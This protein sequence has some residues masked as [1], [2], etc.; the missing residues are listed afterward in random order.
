MTTL[1]ELVDQEAN[2]AVAR[3]RRTGTANRPITDREL[4]DELTN[5]VYSIL[6]RLPANFDKKDL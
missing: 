6:F 2:N 1:K 5:L 4:K 3:I